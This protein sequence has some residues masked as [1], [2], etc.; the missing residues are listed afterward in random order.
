[1][2][3][4]VLTIAT[5]TATLLSAISVIFLV[6][7]KYIQ[8]RANKM[9]LVITP[10]KRLANS[11]DEVFYLYLSFSN[12]SALPISILDLRIYESGDYATTC[13]SSN[14]ESGTLTVDAVKVTETDR[15][16]QTVMTDYHT[17]SST[18]PFVIKPYGVFSGYFAFHEAGQD[19]F[20]MCHKNVELF[21]TTSR[22][23]YKIEL[24]LNAYNLYDYS[25]RDDG[26]IFGRAVSG[27]AYQ[28]TSMPNTYPFI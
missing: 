2:M 16:R 28:D 1:M 9:K 13:T 25:Y 18:V 14:H 15:V 23:A 26:L 22:K 21:I 17:L 20:I 11:I 5:V 10:K 6:R 7:D 19:S 4:T 3:E 24:D 8:K 27:K 12:E